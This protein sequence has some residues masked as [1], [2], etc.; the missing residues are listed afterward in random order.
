MSFSAKIDSSTSI[1]C[2]PV[3]IA[4]VIAMVVRHVRNVVVLVGV[5]GS[6]VVPMESTHGQTDHRHTFHETSSDVT[7]N[8][9][10]RSTSTSALSHRGHQI[11]HGDV[12]SDCRA[13]RAAHHFGG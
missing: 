12:I 9:L 4:A 11:D 3:S 8:S 1:R 7:R 10:P 5:H 13:A 2:W 6:V